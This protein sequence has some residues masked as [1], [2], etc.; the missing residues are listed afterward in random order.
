MW[1][2][3]LLGLT[4]DSRCKIRSS[5]VRYQC[6]WICNFYSDLFIRDVV[7]PSLQVLI[8]YSYIFLWWQF[9]T[10]VSKPDWNLQDNRYCCIMS[11]EWSFTDQLNF[12]LMKI[13]NKIPSAFKTASFLQSS[14]ISGVNST[15]HSATS[16]RVSNLTDIRFF[17]IYNKG[18]S[19]W[20]SI[21][22]SCYER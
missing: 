9:G 1:V 2:W 7:I 22:R 16:A 10:G 21:E 15:L 5:W 4:V 14:Y 17:K 20:L 13:R 3:I 6:L 18:A 8:R 19:C 12:T 11:L